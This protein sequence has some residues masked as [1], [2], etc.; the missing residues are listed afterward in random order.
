[1]RREGHGEAGVSEPAEPSLVLG[2]RRGRPE[3]V[4]PVCSGTAPL[5]S[6]PFPPAAADRQPSAPAPPRR[7]RRRL[8]VA[9]RRTTP[10]PTARPA[11]AVHAAQWPGLPGRPG[12]ELLLAARGEP[13]AVPPGH[14]PAG[15]GPDG[16]HRSGGLGA[17]RT[18]VAARRG[19]LLALG[20]RAR[21]PDQGGQP[22][23][24]AGAELDPDP[25]PGGQPGHGVQ[26]HVPGDGHVDHGRVVEPPVHVGQPVGR[27]ADA[28]VADLDKHPAAAQLHDG[29]A[30]LGALRREQRGVLDELGEQVHDVGGGLPGDHDPWLD[31]ERHP[32]VLLDLAAAAR[33]TS[34]SGTEL[35]PLAHR[36]LAREHEQVL[37]VPPHPGDQVV[38]GEQLGQ[39]VRVVLALLHD[40]DH[41]GQPVDQRHAAPRQADEH[42]VEAAAQLRLVAGQP[43]RLGV[44]LVERA[45]HPADLVGGLDADRLDVGGPSRAVRARGRGGHPRG[46]PDGRDLKRVRLAACAAG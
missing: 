3:V 25:V 1:M 42:R 43:H 39:L 27:D 17:E 46:Q 38:H 32:A 28:V 15:R 11:H 26:P 45:G 16:C 40:V 23:R 34:V 24:G 35:G 14:V 36:L 44:H 29:D 21:Q 13:G 31:G 37:R 9:W 10:S 19:C 2:T 6:P 5:P 22:L 41:A 33:A 12:R 20:E 30:D 4:S 18:G 7:W 8:T